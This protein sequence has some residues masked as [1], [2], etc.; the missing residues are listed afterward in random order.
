MEIVIDTYMHDENYYTLK[1]KGYN[2][3]I[4]LG[5]VSQFVF[6]NSHEDYIKFLSKINH[7]SESR[8]YHDVLLFKTTEDAQNAIDILNSIMMLN[9]LTQ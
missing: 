6:N 8:R 5:W 3:Y 1:V 2:Y 4:H 9:A 7:S